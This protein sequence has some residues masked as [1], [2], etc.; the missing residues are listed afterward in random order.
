VTQ[1]EHEIVRIGIS[2]AR[3]LGI[4]RERID[5]IDAAGQELFLDLEECARGWGRWRDSQRQD[6]RAL[7]GWNEESIAAWNARCIGQRG[8]SWAE[9]MNERKTRFE[10]ATFDALHRELLSP[11]METGWHTF[12]T[13]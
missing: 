11:L 3:I 13:T 8:G 10:F 2:G 9:F 12:D 6:F 4:S 1:P 7:P 5:Y